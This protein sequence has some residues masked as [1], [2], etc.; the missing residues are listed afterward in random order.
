MG[1]S[2]ML[3][4]ELSS[5]NMQV[6]GATTTSKYLQIIEKDAG[7]ARRLENITLEEPNIQDS[8]TILR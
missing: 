8:I 4:P 3:L 7:L 5:G 6:I 2:E 1:L